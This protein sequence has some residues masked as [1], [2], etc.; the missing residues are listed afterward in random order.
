MR[1]WQKGFK[2]P[3]FRHDHKFVRNVEAVM[4]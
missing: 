2:F 4:K 1:V 3:D